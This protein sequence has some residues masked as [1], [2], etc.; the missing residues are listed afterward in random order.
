MSIDGFVSIFA[1]N[2]YTHVFLPFFCA[3]CV[4]CF[5]FRICVILYFFPKIIVFSLS[6]KRKSACNSCRVIVILKQLVMC[7]EI[8]V[9]SIEKLVNICLPT[10]FFFPF[11][12]APYRA[13][14]LFGCI[15]CSSK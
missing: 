6:H 11:L 14:P 15:C 4:S 2:V 9:T 8:D 5:F 7:C 13:V 3:L 1:P 12:Y 10:Y